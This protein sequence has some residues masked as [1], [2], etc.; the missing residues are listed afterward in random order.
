MFHIKNNCGQCSNYKKVK[1]ADFFYKVFLAIS[2]WKI[3]G[4]EM[5]NNSVRHRMMQKQY[6]L[7]LLNARRL[8]R[9]RRNKL[10][11][12]GEESPDPEEQRK[13]AVLKVAKELYER[14]V[15]TGTDNP[16]VDDITEQLGTA[17]G[18]EVLLTY[19][20]PAPLRDEH[21]KLLR[22]PDNK[23]GS[24]TMLSEDEQT[25]ALHLLWEITLKIVDKSMV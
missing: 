4:M 7:Q 23:Q 1:K 11:E 15:F 21:L 25:K 17:L 8:A 9:Y 14:L 10:L 22:M 13:A 2:D 12:T 24:P 16:M 3:E 6:E 18:S 19:P 5:G 20:A